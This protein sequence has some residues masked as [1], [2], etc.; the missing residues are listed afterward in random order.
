MKNENSPK[1]VNICHFVKNNSH[2]VATE[3]ENNVTI[4]HTFQTL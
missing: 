3:N 1:K 2:K 4:G